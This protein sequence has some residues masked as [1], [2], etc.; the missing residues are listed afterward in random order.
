MQPSRM[1][2]RVLS[3]VFL[4]TASIAEAQETKS[5]SK[6][7]LSEI[8][9]LALD[10]NPRLAGA[11]ADLTEQHGEQIAAAAY[12]NPSLE[13]LGGRGMPRGGDNRA[14]GSE[15]SVALR[16]PLEWPGKRAARMR[17]AEQAVT[18]ARTGVEE[19]RLD[20]RTEVKIA[21][22]QLLLANHEAKLAVENL[23][24][25]EEM[26]RA[27]NRRVAV[28]EGAR[29]EA[30]KAEVEV[31]KG[32]KEMER[33]R[34][35]VE[36]ARAAL[37][38]L[39][40][41][42][43]GD[44]FDIAGEFERPPTVLDRSVLIARIEQHPAL[45]RQAQKL[46]RF[47]QRVIQ[48][49]QA[50]IPDISLEGAYTQEFDRQAYAFGLAVPLPIWSQRQGEIAAALGAQRRAEAD[51]LK[52]RTE[53]TKSLIQHHQDTQSTAN[54]LAVF[55]KGLLKQAEEALRMAQF[56]FRQGASTLLE[57]LDAQRVYRQTLQEY[58]QARFNLSVALAQL[59]R[60]AGGAP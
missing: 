13:G 22:Y 23:A 59:E 38:A 37:N 1:F 42:G 56:S 32:R 8:L 21:F 35:A 19:A 46:Q 57:L 60:S 52:A 26:A 25:V 18:A 11:E 48:E 31:L 20:L 34:A 27:I 3:I 40:A 5:D 2:A 43:L 53:L 24:T 45:K 6:Y 17:A 58:A 30:V 54:Q 14:V 39:T 7:T 29:F 15:Y 49:R 16:Q 51:L 55:E 9:T 44:L 28:G 10:H 12:P 50:R 33:T 4:L 41:G 47:Q 36:V